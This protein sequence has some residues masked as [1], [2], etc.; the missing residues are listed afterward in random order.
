MSQ[1]ASDIHPDVLQLTQKIVDKV[2][3]L[4]AGVETLDANNWLDKADDIDKLNEQLQAMLLPP[5]PQK[6]TTKAQ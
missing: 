2:N 4:V 1:A 6:R 5:Q 3:E